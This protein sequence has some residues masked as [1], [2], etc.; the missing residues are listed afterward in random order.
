M[1]IRDSHHAEQREIDGVTYM[2]CGDWVESCTALAEG[3][4]GNIEIL[5]WVDFD[6]LNMTPARDGAVEPLLETGAA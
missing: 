5:R 3:F 6:R 1:C 4:D 2:N